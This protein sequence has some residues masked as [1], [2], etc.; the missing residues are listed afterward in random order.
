MPCSAPGPASR[1]RHRLGTGSQEVPY[2]AYDA[3]CCLGWPL[4][5][6]IASQVVL[7]NLV[8]VCESSQADGL[9]TLARAGLGV[10]WLPR[11]APHGD[12]ASGQLVQEGGPDLMISLE[13]QLY[14][15]PRRLSPAM[16]TFLE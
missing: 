13:I 8:V 5:R 15:P 14:R 12:V 2:L 10:A 4:Q 1:P 9:R 3:E 7:N 6:L 16:R 11:S